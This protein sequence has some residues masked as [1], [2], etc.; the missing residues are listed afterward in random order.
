MNNDII[1]YFAV[2]GLLIASLIPVVIGIF[3]FMKLNKQPASSS[4][5]P[6]KNLQ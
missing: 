2:G 3:H 1:G 6:G 4:T 5:Y